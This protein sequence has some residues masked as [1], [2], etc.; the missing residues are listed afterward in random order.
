MISRF[1]RIASGC[2][3]ALCV[4]A[5]AGFAGVD[6]NLI[7]TT[8]SG[9][10]GLPLPSRALLLLPSSMELLDDKMPL[11]AGDSFAYAVLEDADDPL[12]LHVDSEGMVKIPLLGVREAAGLT[13]LKFAKSLQKELEADYYY[14][15]TVIVDRAL[16]AKGKVF[17][18]GEIVTSGSM[19]LP[20]SQVWT[21]S[22]ALLT[23][24]GFTEQAD[25]ARV[26]LIRK[27]PDSPKAESRQEYDIGKMLS[28]GDFSNDPV[29]QPGD[30][31]FVSA[32]NMTARVTVSGQVLTPGVYSIP[33]SDFTVSQAILSA[34]G[35]GK[36][37][38]AR[39][40]RLIRQNK[41]TNET[42][43]TL[44]DLK[45]VFE[46]G[47]HDFDPVVLPNDTISVPERFINF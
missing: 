29:L 35:L 22:K 44:V 5:C 39:K 43:V 1:L 20:P 11:Q 31:I 47:R 16:P 15:A 38:N 6:T 37:A 12:A 27:D 21:L 7:P 25:R 32:I 34:G 46:E 10:A 9:V 17:I 14:K 4:F 18:S 41:D 2:L 13:P 33:T 24:G 28:T 42:S 40:V 36:Y 23:A 45:K 19:E 26:A 3:S 30:L 8:P